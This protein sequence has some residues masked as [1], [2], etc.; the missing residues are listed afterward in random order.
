M[1]EGGHIYIKED[2]L[3]TESGRFELADGEV[4]KIWVR[5]RPGV[6]NPITDPESRDEAMDCYMHGY[7]ISKEQY[8]RY[9]SRLGLIACGLVENHVHA[10]YDDEDFEK[11]GAKGRKFGY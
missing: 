10:D 8:D 9:D 11:E 6:A 4:K 5:V 3:R 2:P 7:E 1:G